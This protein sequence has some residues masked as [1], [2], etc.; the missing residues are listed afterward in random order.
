[1]AANKQ[2]IYPLS[3]LQEPERFSFLG[4][5]LSPGD[6]QAIMHGSA[7]IGPDKGC[8]GTGK[9]RF[10]RDV[11]SFR[12]IADESEIRPCLQLMGQDRGMGNEKLPSPHSNG[13]GSTLRGR[14]PIQRLLQGSI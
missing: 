12:K 6:H 5:L 9:G 10:R 3:L 13:R 4:R 1:L 8:K 14:L 11:L 2:G 7:Q